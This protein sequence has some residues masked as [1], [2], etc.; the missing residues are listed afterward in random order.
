MKKKL[1]IAIP[2]VLFLIAV[3]FFAEKYFFRAED[4]APAAD[5][6][7][8]AA[9]SNL[10]F[11][12]PL[13]K[14]VIRLTQNKRELTL[15]YDIDIYIEGSAEFEAMNGALGKAKFRDSMNA[16]VAELTAT[17]IWITDEKSIN[18][19]DT[20]LT[21]QLVRRLNRKFPSV[22]TAKITL[23]GSTVSVMQ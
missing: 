3:G 8:H 13:G 23:V 7:N 2:A 9:Q 18:L 5:T 17:T 10:L 12:M 22:R 11:K 19:T 16:V 15:L 20:E 4:L 21:E 1:I 14:F 6:Q